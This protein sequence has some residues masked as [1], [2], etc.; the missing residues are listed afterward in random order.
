MIK[1]DYKTVA[2]AIRF[3]TSPSRWG[4]TY[5]AQAAAILS[6][7]PAIKRAAR[8]LR[9]VPADRQSLTVL[10]ALLFCGEEWG[11]FVAMEGDR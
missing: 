8:K 9:A 11:F 1:Q 3:V 10:G 7:V 4:N 2:G 6:S 5:A